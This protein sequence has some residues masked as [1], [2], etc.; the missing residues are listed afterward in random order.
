MP[1]IKKFFRREV[2]EDN[3]THHLTLR[4]SHESAPRGGV[5]Q[6]SKAKKPEVRFYG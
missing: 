3:F 4:S 1:S 5:D 6:Y 2:R